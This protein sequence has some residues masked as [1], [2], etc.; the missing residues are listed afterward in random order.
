MKAYLS[1]SLL[2]PVCYHCP[3]KS[4]AAGS[5]FTL[6]DYW[7]V[8]SL[9]PELD[10]DLGIGIAFVHT[11]KAQQVLDLLPIAKYPLSASFE[12]IVRYNHSIAKPVNPPL[13]LKRYLFYVESLIYYCFLAQHMRIQGKS[14]HRNY[15]LC[16]PNPR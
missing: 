11:S 7:G 10:D 1:D 4:F 2:R 5:D 9:Q 14:C 16:H 15:R 12:Q 8:H 13:R 3:S 6:A